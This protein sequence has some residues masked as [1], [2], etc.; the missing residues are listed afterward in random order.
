MNAENSEQKPKT[1][2]SSRPNPQPAKKKGLVILNTGNGKGKTTAALGIIMRAWGRNMRV[3]VIQFIKN[4]NARFGEIRAAEKMGIDWQVTGSG[5]VFP[6]EDQ[7]E[8]R[9]KAISGWKLAQDWI[10]SNRYDVLL[11][12]EIT[13][14]LQFGWLDTEEV[15][16]WIKENKP[17]MLHLILTGRNAPDKL[18]AF[19]DLVTEMRE[20][21]HPYNEQGIIA[22]AGIE[23]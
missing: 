1:I 11:L 9:Q 6:G 18:I 19:A 17:H 22:Q 14:P 8:A 16:A 12:D 15:I 13:Y 3:G 23:F 10:T 5:W 21:K 2:R 4:E 7:T 20:I